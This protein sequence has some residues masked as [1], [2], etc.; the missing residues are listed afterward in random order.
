MDLYWHPN[1]EIGESS[2]TIPSMIDIN[3]ILAGKYK[4]NMTEIQLRN[5]GL[6][7]VDVTFNFENEDFI[8]SPAQLHINRSETQTSYIYALPTSAAVITSKLIGWIKDNPEPITLQF[9][10][11]GVLP[12]LTVQTKVVNFG[13]LPLNK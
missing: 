3:S 5:S 9:S 13:R 1:H 11:T 7:D 12:A 10:M 6:H 8:I 2:L 4:E